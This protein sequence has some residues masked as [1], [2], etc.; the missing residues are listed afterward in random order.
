MSRVNDPAKML[1]AEEKLRKTLDKIG[2]TF[3]PDPKL[4]NMIVSSKDKVLKIANRCFYRESGMCMTHIDG[5]HKHE[6]ITKPITED[7]WF[8]VQLRGLIEYNFNV[9]R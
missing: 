1:I 7:M 5:E 4:P 8:N 3:Y 6:I 9:I 2:I